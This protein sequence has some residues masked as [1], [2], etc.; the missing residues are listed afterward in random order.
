[1]RG[2]RTFIIL[3][4]IAIPLGWFVYRDSQRPAGDGEAK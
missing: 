2:L 1:M 3:L 4:L